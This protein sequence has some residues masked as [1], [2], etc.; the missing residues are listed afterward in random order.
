MGVNWGF[1]FMFPT[2]LEPGPGPWGGYDIYEKDTVSAWKQILDWISK[3]GFSRLLAEIPPRYKDR[4]INGWGY[5]YVLDFADFPEAQAFTPGFVRR[6]REK[7]ASR[8]R[9]KQ[10]AASGSS[11]CQRRYQARKATSAWR[12]FSAA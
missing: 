6:N 8:S 1:W 12:R 9:F 5:H 4:V 11:G 10:S 2:L 7:M 3:A